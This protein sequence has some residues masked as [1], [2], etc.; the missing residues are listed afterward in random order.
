MSASSSIE[1]ETGSKVLLLH[2][3]DTDGI[4]SA[5]LLLESLEDREV[6]IETFTPTIGNYL[7]DSSDKESIEK[8]DPDEVIVVDMALPSES[9]KFLSGFGPVKIFDHHL[10]QK[11]DVELHYNPIIEGASPEEYPSATWVV[12]DFLDRKFDFLTVLGAFG[13]REEKLKENDLA[14]KTVEKVLSDL[15]VDFDDLLDPVELIDTL[16]KMGDRDSVTEMPWFLKGVKEPREI[17][18]REDLREN[19]RKL[20]EAI[21]REVEGDLVKVKEDVLY[22]EMTSPYNIISTV[23]RRLAWSREDKKVVVSNSEYQKGK[24]QI[25]IRGP[26]ENSET[27]IEEMKGKGYSAGGKSDVVGMVVPEEDE[28]E[29]LE[30]LF[31]MI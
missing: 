30:D 4:A 9:V 25:Y 8:I 23:T 18:E 1:I 20:K 7:I 21:E 2:H 19:W 13:D 16:Y 28:E 3:W 31:D 27:V 10:Q 22:R 5:T 24:S 6:E 15:D 14:M 11:H 12:T 29:V 26:L 17:L